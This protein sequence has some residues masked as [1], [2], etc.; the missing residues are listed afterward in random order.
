MAL[1]IPFYVYGIVSYGGPVPNASI[2]CSDETSTVSATTNADGKYE[3]NIQDVATNGDT[4]TITCSYG[5][6]SY[7]SSFSL[8]IVTQVSYQINFTGIPRRIMSTFVQGKSFFV[9]K[10]GIDIS[11]LSI[12]SI[13]RWYA[14]STFEV[15]INSP[16]TGFTNI[17]N[18]FYGLAEGGT[19][20][21]SYSWTFG[22]GGTSTLQNPT[23][24]YTSA[25]TF[26][27]VLTVTDGITTKSDSAT[28]V[29]STPGF[30]NLTI[31]ECYNYWHTAD[32]SIQYCAD[33]RTQGEWDIDH[34]AS[35]FQ[36]YSA[37]YP[38]LWID[39]YLK[40]AA[41][42][43]TFMTTYQ[44]KAVILYCRT[45]GR[46]AIAAQNLVNAG[47]TTTYGGTVYNM[48]GGIDAW[49]EAG[50]PSTN[51]GG[52]FYLIRGIWNDDTGTKISLTNY[53]DIG[54]YDITTY[55][56]N[57]YTCT[58]VCETVWIRA[59]PATGYHFVKWN[60]CSCVN[61]HTENPDSF[62]MDGT[63]NIECV[64]AAD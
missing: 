52:S 3:L 7:S 24:T 31:A 35:T 59:Y 41:Q 49:V 33:V 19:A 32:G 40:T 13:P 42:L 46:S 14:I 34:I 55:R 22:D 36:A 4:I 39:L 60:G 12:T 16:T 29:I 27:V 10:R 63:K 54:Y 53:S 6:N 25:N 43:V 57:G 58:P 8:N 62:L 2:T 47:F 48:L 56:P 28:I 1:A 26:T 44:N 15:Y 50:Y 9:R 61:G 37:E 23:H 51:P 38:S 21:Y 64:F 18:Q 20:T 5:G 45:G 11:H 17:S 30:T